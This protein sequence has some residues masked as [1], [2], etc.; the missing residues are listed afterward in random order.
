MDK[1]KRRKGEQYLRKWARSILDMEKLQIEINQLREKKATFEDIQMRNKDDINTIYQDVI[2]KRIEKLK[3]TIERY[4]FVDDVI[5]NLEVHEREII[6]ARY[7]QK[8]AWQLIALDVHIRER[9]CFNIKNRV[10]N[11]ILEKEEC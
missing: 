9:Q 4:K 11:K 2:S 6:N 5:S 8:R 1:E 3:E 7:K 10:I